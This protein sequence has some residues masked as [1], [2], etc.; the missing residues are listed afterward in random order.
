MHNFGGWKS[1][2]GRAAGVGVSADI[3]GVDQI[4]HLHVGEL[5]GQSDGVERVAGGAKDGANLRGALLEA[6]DAVLAVV[7]DYTAIGVID[8]IIDVIA[9]L[10][11]PK[12]FA[13]DL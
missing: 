8:A 1:V 11:A 13:N 6:S 12:S 7:K 9:E 10:S 4:S 5:G 3:F 2:E